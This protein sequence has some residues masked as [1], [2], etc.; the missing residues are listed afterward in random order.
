VAR[1]RPSVELCSFVA[2]APVHRRAIYAE[3]ARAASALASGSRVLDAGAGDA[4]YRPLFA[5]CSYVTQDWPESVH[6][7][8]ARA[9]IVADLHRLPAGVGDFDF[10]VCTEVIEHV[11]KPERV[12]AELA[13]VTRPG[14][15]LL[16][17]VPFVGALHEE[18]HDY[19]RPTSHALHHL[20]EEAG[21]RDVE[22]EPLTGWWGMLAHT[23]RFYGLATHPV[24]RRPGLAARVT[25]LALLGLSQLL[26]A[27]VPALD[28]L[29]SRRALPLGWSCRAVRGV[30]DTRRPS[31]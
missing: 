11:V 26:T 28:R 2:Q 25:A 10:V 3:V 27:L 12:L 22:V 8:G 20:L 30:P 14:G 6:A 5:H 21:F 1:E 31:V 18:P 17:T 7:G 24:G 16:L 4:P 15:G 23:L 13:R 29:D 19:W 9:D